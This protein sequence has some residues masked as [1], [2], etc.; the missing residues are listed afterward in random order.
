MLAT[1]GILWF[2]DLSKPDAYGILPI[3]LA[4]V[5]LVNI[6]VNPFLLGSTSKHFKCHQHTAVVIQF[7]QLFYCSFMY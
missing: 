2:T 6:E 4:I 3:L 1:E 7:V 5:N